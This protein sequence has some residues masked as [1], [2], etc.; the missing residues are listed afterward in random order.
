MGERGRSKCSEEAAGLDSIKYLDLRF[1]IGALTSVDTGLGVD[2]L[3][4]LF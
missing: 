3:L 4:V 2:L 1:L